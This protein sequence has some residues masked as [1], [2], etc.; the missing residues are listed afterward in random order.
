MVEAGI[1]IIPTGQE[2]ISAGLIDAGGYATG[3]GLAGEA[4]G[5]MTEAVGGG[6]KEVGGVIHHYGDTPR[7]NIKAEHEDHYL[8]AQGSYDDDKNLDGFT[9]DKELSNRKVPVC[10]SV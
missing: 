7:E 2:E 1:V 10:A 9:Y 5:E 4:F 8:V 3:I 6:I